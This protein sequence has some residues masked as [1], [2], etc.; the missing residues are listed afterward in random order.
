MRKI[1]L[2]NFYKTFSYTNVELLKKLVATTIGF[3][4]LS[5]NNFLYKVYLL[6]NS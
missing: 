2:C 4:L 5:C 6:S 1:T 3:K